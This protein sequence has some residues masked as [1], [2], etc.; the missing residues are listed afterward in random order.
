MNFSARE[1]SPTKWVTSYGST[2]GASNV[3]MTFCLRYATSLDLFVT[4]VL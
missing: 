1:S 2:G 4:V 3:G